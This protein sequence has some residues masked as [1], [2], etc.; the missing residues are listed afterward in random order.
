VKKLLAEYKEF[1][2]KG[3]VVVVAVGLIM[4][5]YFAEIVN[6]VLEG[7]LMPIISAIFGESDFAHIGFDIGDARISIGLVIDAAIKFLA[8]AFLLFL[9]VKAYNSWRKEEPEEAG[10]TEIELLTDIRDSLRNR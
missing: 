2:N 9:I 4:A 3:D 1:I 6:A 8:V 10:P 7:V 5:L